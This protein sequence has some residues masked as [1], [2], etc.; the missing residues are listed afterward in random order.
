MQASL[1]L[2][3]QPGFIRV[4]SCVLLSSGCTTPQSTPEPRRSGAPKREQRAGPSGDIPARVAKAEEIGAL[5]ARVVENAESHLAEAPYSQVWFAVDRAALEHNI[6]FV[7]ERIAPRKLCAVVKGDAYGV[8]LEIAAKVFAE[9]TDMFCISDNREAAKLRALGMEHPIVRIRLASPSEVEASVRA[10]LELQ[11]FLGSLAMA[12]RYDEIVAQYGK[13]EEKLG[14]HVVLNSTGMGRNGFP[15]GEQAEETL[16]QMAELAALPHLDV[17]AI[18][19]HL[20][21]AYK[22]DFGPTLAKARRFLEDAR[23]VNDVLAEAGHA[24]IWHL[25]NSAAST[26][27]PQEIH[28]HLQ[29][30]RVGGQL[31]GMKNFGAEDLSLTREPVTVIGH[32]AT[33]HNRMQGDTLGYGST[34][35]VPLDDFKVANIGVGWQN[36]P[37]QLSNRGF[38]VDAGGYTHPILGKLSMNT[39]VVAAAGEGGS[40]LKQGDPVVLLSPLGPT[41]DEVAEMIGQPPSYV[42]MSISKSNVLKFAY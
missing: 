7:K 20:P 34:A 35:Q 38:V 26:R 8:G 31:Y 40:V 4:L 19:A 1:L 10:G 42:T 33:V 6:R 23:R 16:A 9:H 32:V 30:D 36:L 5:L 13:P 11:E 15:M 17:V 29:M 12:K 25:S 2:R 28:D 21:G 24:P 14:V 3:R 39:T 27:L 18:T 22:D 41:I 37:R